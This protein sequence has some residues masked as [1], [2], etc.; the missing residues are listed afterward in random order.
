MSISDLIK[1]NKRLAEVNSQLIQQIKVLSKS[2]LDYQTT[3]HNR[4]VASSL[5]ITNN[6]F[7]SGANNCYF[8]TNVVAYG[9][10]AKTNNNNLWVTYPLPD[11]YVSGQDLTLDLRIRMS[12]GANPDVVDYKII[13]VRIGDGFGPVTNETLDATWS[14]N[15]TG[16]RIHKEILTIDGTNI[17]AGDFILIEVFMEDDNNVN[18]MFLYGIKLTV[19]VI[20]RV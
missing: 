6:G 2:N 19:P 18:I 3:Q 14:E 4:E 9:A 12:G 20:A 7:T 10:S 1:R 5:T 16:N 17:N 11:D 8:L 13:S 15:F